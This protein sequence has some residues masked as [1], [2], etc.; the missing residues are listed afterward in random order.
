MSQEKNYSEAAEKALQE[1]WKLVNVRDG[2]KSAK[3][4]FFFVFPAKSS[5]KVE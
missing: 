2:W 3:V 5:S 4:C 1:S